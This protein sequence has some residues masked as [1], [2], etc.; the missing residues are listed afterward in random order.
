MTFTVAGRTY[1]ATAGTVLLVPRDVAHS[2]H[3]VGDGP[4]RMLFLYS[5][6][7]MEGMFPELG[8]PGRRGVIPPPLNPAD[9]TAMAAVADKYGFSFLTGDVT[10]Q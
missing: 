6:P 3:N 7:G 10:A 5:P 1:D 2:Y 8:A 4:A 9:I